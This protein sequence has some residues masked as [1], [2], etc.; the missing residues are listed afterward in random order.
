MLP[1]NVADLISKKYE[2]AV[3]NGHLCF[4]ESTTKKLKDANSG[5]NYV[6][7]YA[8]S[9][10][11]KPERG[12]QPDKNP[13]AE[14]EPELTVVENVADGEY[15]LLLNKFPIVPEHTLLVTNTFKDQKSPLSPLDLMTAYNLLLKLDDEDENKRHM[16]IYNS[17]PS[18][19][20]SQ[21]HKHLQTLRLP[22]NFVTLQDRICA[23][24]SHFLPD[25]KTE[26]LQDDK[27]SFAH[28]VLPLPESEEDVNEDL[29]AMCYV[30]LVQ[31]A[32]TFFQDWAGEKPEL[33]NSR[34]YNV[35]MTKNWICVVPRSSTRAKS[36]QIGFN[37][38]GYA[39]LILV[40]TQEAYDQIL[41]LPHKIDEA[42]LECGFP[43]SAGKKQTEYNY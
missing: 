18:S 24:K 23:G 29:L 27:V 38:T 33:A 40:K 15:K 9:L 42:L 6:V 34:G 43:N 7:S 8:P 1:E 35:L 28:F 4:T 5:M 20:S 36:L 19:G 11:S 17:G 25:F 2:E 32:F 41:Q 13:F 16:M 3:N 30:S 21:D 26:P 39:G 37:A 12:D 31:R 10:A 14:P 22:Q